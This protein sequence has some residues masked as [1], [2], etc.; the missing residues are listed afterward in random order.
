MSKPPSPP[1]ASK[2]FGVAQLGRS[3]WA[4]VIGQSC[5]I[6]SITLGAELALEQ[7]GAVEAAVVGDLVVRVGVGVGGRPGSVAAADRRRCAWARCSDRAA[8]IDSRTA[9]VG[10]GSG[11]GRVGRG[12]GL[13]GRPTAGGCA[14]RGWLRRRAGGPLD[15]RRPS[16]RRLRR[17]VDDRLDLPVGADHVDRRLPQDLVAAAADEGVA[18]PGVA[19][20]DGQGGRRRRRSPGRSG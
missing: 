19:E 1:R 14:R 20:A 15:A 10:R 8:A 13:V 9:G 17:R 16:R 11:R 18:R 3:W 4:A 5:G 2:G 6:S 7:L 12:G